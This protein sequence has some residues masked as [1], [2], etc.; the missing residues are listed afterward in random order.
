MA[1]KLQDL[2]AE[3]RR[4]KGVSLRKVESETGISNAYVS[5]LETGAV[6]EPS[7]K[8]LHA[9]AKYYNLSYG[10]LMNACGYVVAQE[11]KNV[12]NQGP[13][14]MGEALSPEEG[15]AVAA[16]LH[17]LRKRSKKR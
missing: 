4:V 1:M 2:L 6:A 8:K 13:S 10:L 11:G 15:A 17:E 14:F 16:F 9:L 12:D 7:P 5:Q 3:A